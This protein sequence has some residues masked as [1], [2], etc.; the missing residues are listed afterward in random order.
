MPRQRIN[1]EPRDVP[2]NLKVTRTH[3][4]KLIAITKHLNNGSDTQTIIQWI[5]A[6]FEANNLKLPKPKKH[7]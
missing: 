4:D 7:P 3:R 6:A 2:L 5:D 1:D